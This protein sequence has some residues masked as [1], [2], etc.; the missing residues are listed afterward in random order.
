[1][2][3]ESRTDVIL[4]HGL[5]MPGIVMS[6]LAAQLGERGFRAHRFD[7]AGRQ[8]PL[9]LH[10]ERL[11]RFAH[12]VG[13]GAPVHFVGHSL[14]GLVVLASLTGPHAAATAG[15]VLL[16]T[17][18]RGC[19]AGR[20]LARLPGGRW[21]L[22]E[23]EPLWR[24]GRLAHWDGRAPLGV[25]AGSLPFGLGRALGSLPGINDGVVRLEET[26]IEGMTERIVLPVS[27]AAM[28]VS[29][30]LAA[31]VAHFLAHGAFAQDD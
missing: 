2:K 25:I 1:M 27:H 26:Q 23:S 28:L 31:Q 3:S 8:R 7:Y 22:G 20:R 14:G 18:V 15:V 29:A 9:E 30:R 6:P 10:A 4:L 19:L 16:G 12:A 17:P 13:H 21:M 11:A 24:E 5:W